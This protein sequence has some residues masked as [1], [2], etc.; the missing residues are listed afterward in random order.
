MNGPT[1][2]TLYTTFNGKPVERRYSNESAAYAFFRL[3]VGNMM[4]CRAMLSHYTADT[5]KPRSVCE[6]TSEFG[7]KMQG[8]A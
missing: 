7:D 5:D 6:V 1:E 4:P 2:Y 3:M 8:V